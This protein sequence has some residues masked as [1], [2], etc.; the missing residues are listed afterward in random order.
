MNK[1]DRI[2]ALAHLGDSLK[3]NAPDLH[4]VKQQA[5]LKNPWF[6]EENQN[7]CLQGWS[8]NLTSENIKKW[9]LGVP[10][11]NKNP[12]KIGLV[13][14]GNIPLV[15]LHDLISV[16]SSGNIAYVKCSHKD[17][18]LMPYAIKILTEFDSRFLELI[19]QQDNLKGIDAIIAT[20]SDNTTRYFEY[21]FSKIPH[22]FRGNRTGVAIITGDETDADLALLADDVFTYFGLGCRNVTKLYIP[23]YYD[24]TKIID[25]FNKYAYLQN[26]FKFSNNYVYHKA[27]LL[28]NLDKHLDSGFV[29]YKQDESL[30]APLGCIFYEFYSDKKLLNDKLK[31]LENE[32]QVLVASSPD[33]DGIPFGTAQ[34]TSLNDFADD[35]NTLTFLANL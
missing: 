2:R 7:F 10:E 26:H 24:V 6:T 1:T 9:L 3:P 12:K 18:V 33:F 25:A 14:A 31:S 13:L 29:V 19:I 21:Y 15:G 32:I 20:G 22:I 8:K 35:V 34:I 16:I 5:E 4:P 28:M 30:H 11:I 27:I 23:D 17:D